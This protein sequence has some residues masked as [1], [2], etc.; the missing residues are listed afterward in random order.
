MQRGDVKTAK[1]DTTTYPMR[2]LP[3]SLGKVEPSVK[4]IRSALVIA[5]QW[6]AISKSSTYWARAEP[7]VLKLWGWADLLDRKHWHVHR[8]ARAWDNDIC[9]KDRV[10]NRVDAING[11]MLQWV[12]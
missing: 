12:L 9:F 4:R 8:R 11:F 3:H 1:T 6:A 5:P 10:K 7:A 2:L